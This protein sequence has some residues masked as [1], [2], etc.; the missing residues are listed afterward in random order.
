MACVLFEPAL[1]KWGAACA[2][3]SAVRGYRPCSRHLWLLRGPKPD[4]QS[5]CLVS[6][7]LRPQTTDSPTAR[8][9]ALGGTAPWSSRIPACG[10]MLATA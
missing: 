10:F 8:A 2:G 5:C 4:D 9:G 3:V 6:F 1:D 7:L